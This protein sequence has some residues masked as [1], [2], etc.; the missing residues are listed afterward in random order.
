[1]VA[2]DNKRA[3]LVE[4]YV[5]GLDETQAAAIAS[6]L[7]AAIRSSE[8]GGE[9]EALLSCALVDEETYLCIIAAPERDD[10]VAATERAGIVCDHVVEVVA[11]DGPTR[12]E[13]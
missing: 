5:A 2:R 9:V 1:V 8:E 7:R 11:M 12:R 10:V 6:R 13:G 3:F 4:T